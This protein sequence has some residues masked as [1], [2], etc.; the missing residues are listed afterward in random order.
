MLQHVG[1]IEQVLLLQFL[2][3]FGKDVFAILVKHVF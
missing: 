2:Y 3:V 1:N